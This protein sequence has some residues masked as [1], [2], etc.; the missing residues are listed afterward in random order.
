MHTNV[1][2][3]NLYFNCCSTEGWKHPKTDV[4][5]SG[6]KKKKKTISAS[7][8]FYAF[9]AACTKDHE[10]RTKCY[11]DQGVREDGNYLPHLGFQM[12]DTVGA[13]YG[14]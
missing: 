10:N 7:R 3:K 8:I 13:L 11:R 1:D 6:L 9:E 14:I 2:N 5:C 12:G 4:L